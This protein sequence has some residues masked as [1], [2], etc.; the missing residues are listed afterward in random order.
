MEKS[1]RSSINRPRSECSMFQTTEW[2]SRLVLPFWRSLCVSGVATAAAV[3]RHDGTG[4]HYHEPTTA[5]LASPS[6][7]YTSG[8]TYIVCFRQI[9]PSFSL[10][11]PV[12][13]LRRRLISHCLSC[14]ILLSERPTSAAAAN[15]QYLSS[16]IRL[17]NDIWSGSAKR[18]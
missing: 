6:H 1:S 3:Q 9:L 13:S 4:W 16:V 17:D 12:S 10:P 11:P 8:H 15:T 7:I 5:L 18:R 14:C 2:L